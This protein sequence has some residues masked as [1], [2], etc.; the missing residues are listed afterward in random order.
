MTASNKLTELHIRQATPSDKVSKLSDGRGM[1]LLLHPNGSKYW[2]MD[3]RHQGKQKILALGIWP[4]VSLKEARE[5]RD[6][7]KK[8]IQNGINPIDLR[9]KDEH[10][11]KQQQEL[12]HIREK[13]TFLNVANEWIGKQALIWSVDHTRRVIRGFENHIW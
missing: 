2:R 1:Y 4:E 5:K 6:Q 3:F 12:I 11:K 10:D 7:A 13:N 9:R 8:I